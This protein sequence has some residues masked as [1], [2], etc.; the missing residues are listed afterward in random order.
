MNWSPCW[1]VWA[2]SLPSASMR[3]TQECLHAQGCRPRT[4][5][6][7][8]SWWWP[9]KVSRPLRALAW[10][11]WSRQMEAANLCTVT[12]RSCSSSGTENRT[13]SSFSAGFLLLEMINLVHGSIKRHSG[14]TDRGIHSHSPTSGTIA[15]TA[16]FHV[17]FKSD[18]IVCATQEVQ[19]SS[20]LISFEGPWVPGTFFFFLIKSVDSMGKIQGSSSSSILSYYNT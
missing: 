8:P 7:D 18:L 15:A 6:T 14:L 13:A 19:R 4:F 9:R 16:Y 20:P 1:K 3:T 2:C 5:C 17:L 11:S 10:A 12:T